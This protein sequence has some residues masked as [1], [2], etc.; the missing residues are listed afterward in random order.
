MI[1]SVA[2]EGSDYGRLDLAPAHGGVDGRGRLKS[3]TSV[4]TGWPRPSLSKNSHTAW[5]AKETSCRGLCGPWGSVG[6]A[7][8]RRRSDR[9][10]LSDDLAVAIPLRADTPGGQL[11]TIEAAVYSAFMPAPLPTL[12][13]VPS[14]E[15]PSTWWG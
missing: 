12:P 6:E 13:Q 4:R 14:I 8:R 2:K 15:E 7:H 1:Q 9:R 3:W 10:E 11:S 5:A